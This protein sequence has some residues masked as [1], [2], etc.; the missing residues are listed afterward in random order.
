MLKYLLPTRSVVLLVLLLLSGCKSKT[1]T[2]SAD[3][4]ADSG[5]EPLLIS[6]ANFQTE[7]L[8]SEQP[9]LVDFWAVRCS[10]CLEMK[11]AIRGL[12]ADFTGRAAI[13]QLD[14]DANPLVPEKY[15]VRQLPTVLIFRNGEVVKRLVGLRTKDE[16]AQALRAVDASSQQPNDND[17]GNRTNH[18]N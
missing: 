1:A 18:Q 11:P 12:V 3:P 17:P 8:D 7:V 4:V 2:D 13:G 16:L 9:V 10:P 6:D 15:D 14:V 5:P